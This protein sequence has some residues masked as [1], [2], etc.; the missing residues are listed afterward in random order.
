MKVLNWFQTHNTVPIK[1]SSASK[2]NYLKN[3]KLFHKI[4]L[5]C[6]TQCLRSIRGFSEIF[7]F[8]LLFVFNWFFFFGI[9]WENCFPRIMQII[10]KSKHSKLRFTILMI[11]N[12]MGKIIIRII[13][14]Y[15]CEEAWT[16]GIILQEHIY[17]Y[18]INQVTCCVIHQFIFIASNCSHAHF[19]CVTIA[20]TCLKRN[21]QIQ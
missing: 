6:V 19:M 8:R 16:A 14:R 10:R 13:K 4:K 21:K 11:L 17:M 9:I 3:L 20:V 12:F 5:T 1:I 18:I 7:F 15:D 2:E